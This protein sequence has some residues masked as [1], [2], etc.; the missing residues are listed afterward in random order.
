MDE[1]REE[2]AGI[3]VPMIRFLLKAKVNH[4]RAQRAT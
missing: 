1:V 2:M 4:N 3:L